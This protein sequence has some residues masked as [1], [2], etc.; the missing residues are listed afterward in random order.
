MQTNNEAIERLYKIYKKSK[1]LKLKMIL[2]NETQL[3]GYLIGH[4]YDARRNN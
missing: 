3:I 4:Y 2:R 1:N